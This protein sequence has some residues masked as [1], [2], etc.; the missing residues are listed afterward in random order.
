MSLHK[1]ALIRYRIIDNML[2]NPYRVFPTIDEIKKKCEDSLFGSDFGNHICKSTIEKDLKA[3]RT[4]AELGFY[5]P[6]KFSRKNL[7][8]YYDDKGYTIQKIPLKQNDIEALKFAANTLFNFRESDVFSEFKFAIEK[9]FDRLNISNEVQDNR[10]KSVVKFD[11]YPEY[12]GN[13][14]LAFIYDAIVNQQKLVFKY[15]KFN[16]EEQ[17]ERTLHP[18]LLKEHRYRWYVIGFS[19]HREK[20]ITFALDRI[21]E[22]STLDNNFEINPS[23]NPDSFFKDAFG[24]TQTDDEVCEVVLHF[25]LSLQGYLK[26]QPLHAS[27]NL[28]VFEEYFE[29]KINVIPGFELFE[30]ILSYGNKVVIKSPSSVKNKVYSLLKDALK[31]Y[32]TND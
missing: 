2:R 4:D 26:T 18:Y 14:H 11:S 16:S 17:S 12:P 6:I 9:I 32:Q 23:F 22:I 31:N 10:I 27:Q 24:I 15:Q 3:M 21:V 25:D 30:K 13:E 8:Y 7:G 5:A 20:V 19:E 1:H 28:V 29:V